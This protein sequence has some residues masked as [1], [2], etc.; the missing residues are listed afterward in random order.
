MNESFWC[1]YVR[2]CIL[3]AVSS[4]FKNLFL[5]KLHAIRLS[6]RLKF[7][8]FN[9]IRYIWFGA[10]KASRI[11]Q[12][13]NKKNTEKMFFKNRQYMKLL[14][15]ILCLKASQLSLE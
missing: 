6:S 12:G 10:D 2:A 8:A 1:R 15:G 9:K 4:Y 11:P 14:H 7:K 5:Y 3:R 13:L